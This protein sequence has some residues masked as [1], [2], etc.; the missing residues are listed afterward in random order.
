MF[1]P[2]LRMAE[3]LAIAFQNHRVTMFKTLMVDVTHLRLRGTVTPGLKELS[4]GV[5]LAWV[6]IEIQTSC[7]NPWV[8]IARAPSSSADRGTAGYFGRPDLT[9]QAPHDGYGHWDLGF[10]HDR[11][12]F[13]CGRNKDAIIIRGANH[14]PQDWRPHSTAWSG[15]AVPQRWRVG[16]V[17]D[18]RT[19]RRWRCS[20]KPRLRRRTV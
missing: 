20:S 19:K 14:A 17:P 8:R 9:D 15:S 6:D 18:V 2:V 4:V 7:R 1:H 10:V 13:I 5:Q 3:S 12:L 16:F 11:E